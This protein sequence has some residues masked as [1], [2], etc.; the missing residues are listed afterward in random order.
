MKKKLWLLWCSLVVIITIIMSW[1]IPDN[2]YE[3]M[4]IIPEHHKDIPVFKGL[5]PTESNYV[6]DDNHWKEIYDFY[7]K[8]LPKHGWKV[9][10]EESSLNDKDTENDWGGFTS[11]W[12]KKGFN[13]ELWIT[14]HFN[15][16]E[17]QTE[18]IFDKTPIYYSTKWIDNIP[19][20]ICI[21]Q[22]INDDKCDEISDK[23]KIEKIAGFINDALDWNKEKLP[24]YRTVIIEIGNM[25]VKVLYKR[26]KE[27][28]LV[29]EKGAK[30][31][32]P[33]GE[34]IELINL[35]Q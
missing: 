24:D 11:R 6:M 18:V 30:F 27:I 22:N 25:D 3:G 20:H 12:R 4:S 9:E 2:T 8:E 23:T 1:T 26:D 19:N 31:M 13:G 32:K 33:E 21:Y 15:K 29:S 10:Y 14:A 35:T 17:K 7:L 28:Y 34:F 16:F 5:E